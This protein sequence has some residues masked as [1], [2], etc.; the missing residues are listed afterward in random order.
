M[1][2]L[3]VLSLSLALAQPLPAQVQAFVRS[4]VDQAQAYI[5]E[6]CVQELRGTCQASFTGE[7]L[8]ILPDSNLSACIKSLEEKDFSCP[9]DYAK[10]GV[11]KMLDVIQ[12][13]ARNIARGLQIEIVIDGK[14]FFTR[15][16][17]R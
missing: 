10:Q 16:R 9:G 4:E 8:L 3:L 14:P 1:K 15:T 13:R 7:K 5:N 17:Q 2:K 12:R 11:I 6:I